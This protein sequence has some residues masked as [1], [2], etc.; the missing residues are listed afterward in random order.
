MLA[1]ASSIFGPLTHSF[2]HSLW[3]QVGVVGICGGHHHFFVCIVVLQAWVIHTTALLGARLAT[4]KGRAHTEHKQST[5]R[6][7]TEQTAEH[8]AEHT[9]SAVALLQ[10]PPKRW[11]TPYDGPDTH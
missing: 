9:E 5:R 8:T 10:P 1:W 7:H 4:Q 6:A 2:T 11:R 3:D